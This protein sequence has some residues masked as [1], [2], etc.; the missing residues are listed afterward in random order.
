MAENVQSEKTPEKVKVAE[1]PS[2]QSAAGLDAFQKKGDDRDRANRWTDGW[3][4]Y[5]GTHYIGRRG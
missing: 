2:Q 3:P 1:N 5:P 4:E